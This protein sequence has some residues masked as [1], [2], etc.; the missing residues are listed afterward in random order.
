M[1]GNCGPKLLTLG[2]CISCLKTGGPNKEHRTDKLPPKPTRRIREGPKRGRRRQL[3][4]CPA[5]LPK[6]LMLESIL[7]ERGAHHQEGPWVGPNT[8]QA[9][10]LARDNLETDPTSI[11]PETAGHK[12]ELSYSLTLL[13][14]APVPFSTKSFIYFVSTC[15]SLDSSF[16]SVRQEPTLGPWKES[17]SRQQ[18]DIRAT[19]SCLM[20]VEHSSILADF[21]KGKHHFLRYIIL[22][23]HQI[24]QFPSLQGPLSQSSL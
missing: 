10:W 17:P 24:D 9:R 7:T 16:P 5:N 14:S 1:L 13:L 19:S 18:A 20:A 11:N 3:I 4:I 23:L 15:V 21:S 12:A 6:T 2:T 8:G 22:L